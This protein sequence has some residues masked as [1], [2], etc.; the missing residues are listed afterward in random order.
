MDASCTG[1]ATDLDAQG[2]ILIRDTTGAVQAYSVGDIEHLRPADG[3]Y[4]NFTLPSDRKI[5]QRQH[6]L[7]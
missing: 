3:S 4:G 1:A 5:L 6:R 2:R 7:R